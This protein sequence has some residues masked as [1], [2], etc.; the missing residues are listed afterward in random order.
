MREWAG[1]AY[2]NADDVIGLLDK[3]CVITEVVGFVRSEK[4]NK[5]NFVVKLELSNATTRM[6]TMNKTSARNISKE[7]GDDP[8]KWKGAT[9]ELSVQVMLVRGESKKVVIAVPILKKPELIKVKQ[10]GVGAA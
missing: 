3:C 4:Y 8:Q 5:D 10:Q 7:L 6:W 2:L 1:A 9:L